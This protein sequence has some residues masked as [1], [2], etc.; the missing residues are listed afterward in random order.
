MRARARVREQCLH[1]LGSSS[2]ASPCSA[3]II[4][5][6]TMYLGSIAVLMSRMQCAR[7]CAHARLDMHMGVGMSAGAGAGAGTGWACMG[8]CLRAHVRACTCMFVRVYVHTCSNWA[9][10]IAACCVSLEVQPVDRRGVEDGRPS[11]KRAESAGYGQL[12]GGSRGSTS[13]SRARRARERR[14]ER[15]HGG[16]SGCA[17]TGEEEPAQPGAPPRSCTTSSRRAGMETLSSRNRPAAKA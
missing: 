7:V 8:S 2:I 14:D 9:I 11:V 4:R 16:D 10:P 17:T 5:P 12:S 6:I 13:R 3:N 1:R 15:E